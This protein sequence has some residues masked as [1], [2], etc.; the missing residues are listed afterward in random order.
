MSSNS[1]PAPPCSGSPSNVQA[2]DCP[3][4]AHKG[5]ECTCDPN[6]TPEEVS[7]SA[8]QVRAAQETLHNDP[9]WE[10]AEAKKKEYQQWLREQ[11]E[12][13]ARNKIT[14]ECKVCHEFA[15]LDLESDNT[16]IAS[17]MCPVCYREAF[18]KASKENAVKCKGCKEPFS[19]SLLD[20][21]GRC[22]ACKVDEDVEPASD[23]SKPLYQ[24]TNGDGSLIFT[25]M[26]HKASTVKPKVL[27]WIWEQRIPAGKITL[28]NGPQGGG[29]S[30]VFCDIIGHTTTG[31]DFGDGALNT[32]GAR[33]VLLA[34][35]EDDEADTI[36]PRLMAAGAN[37][38]NVEIFD[39]LEVE[40]V[41]KS[42]GGNVLNRGKKKKKMLDLKLHTKLLKGII[43]KYQ[44]VALI[45]LDPITAFLGV[46]ECKDKEARPVLESI[47]EALQGTECSLIGIIHSNKMTAGS[48]GDKVKGGSSMLGVPRA[49][50][51]V[52]RDPDDKTKRYMALIKANGVEQESG[53]NFVIENKVLDENTGLKAG[54][55]VW[56]GVL[57]ENANELLNAQRESG[58]EDNKARKRNKAKD[59][60]MGLLANAPMRSPD[61]YD[62]GKKENISGDTMKEAAKQLTNEGELLRKQRSDGWWMGLPKHK[63]LLEQKDPIIVEDVQVGDV[64]QL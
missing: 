26:T 64:E 48:A 20:S 31:T 33:K 9:L 3:Y 18:N 28:L 30:M 45:L 22:E 47:A 39:K 8:A 12:E 24:A 55:V 4:N 25:V 19:K 53:L 1:K 29:K 41:I 63:D 6:L 27:K 5:G 10:E 61:V 16:L 46:D 56:K 40:Q 35:T 34:S 51:A 15:T 59:L 37:L 32:L 49:A 54:Y 17:K 44:D 62:T 13:N 52:G 43:K 21:D 2:H 60:I 36:I 38:D 14:I 23:N 50:W 58:K 42:V 57:E 7:A 11:E